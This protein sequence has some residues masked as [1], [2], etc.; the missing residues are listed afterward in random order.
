MHIQRW[1]QFNNVL[2]SCVYPL[3]QCCTQWQDALLSS[4]F[5]SFSVNILVPVGKCPCMCVYFYRALE[6]Q[7]VPLVQRAKVED[8]RSQERVHDLKW[9]LGGEKAKITEDMLVEKNSSMDTAEVFKL[10]NCSCGSSSAITASVH[11]CCRGRRWGQHSCP[12]AWCWCQG[13]SFCELCLEHT[14]IPEE[15][16]SSLA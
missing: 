15:Q 3:I 10:Y 8:I 4:T 14:K 12:P 13:K 16:I 7:D 2:F 5:C 11:I 9:L 6:A 1:F